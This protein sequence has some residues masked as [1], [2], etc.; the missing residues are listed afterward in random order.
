MSSFIILGAG[1]ISVAVGVP[2]VIRGTKEIL[3]SICRPVKIHKT[4]N[5]NK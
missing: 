5:N 3:E 1:L 4:D 2:L